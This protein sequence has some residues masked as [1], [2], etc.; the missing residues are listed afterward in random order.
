MNY[1]YTHGES[2]NPY[3]SLY[4]YKPAGS[5]YELTGRKDSVVIEPM[6]GQPDHMANVTLGIKIRNFQSYFSY[7]YASDK[8][9]GTHPNDL[10]LYVIRE[11]YSRLDFNA[12]YSFT[13]KNS[14]KLELILQV[15]NLNNSE[16]RIRYRE[17]FRPI[18]VEQY[19]VTSNLGVR[20]TF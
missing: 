1:T 6:T 8:I 3:T 9:E 2:P 19:G 5:R 12:S 17:E 13:F 4:K 18:S 7:Q 10:R 15:A 14:G 11:K 20:Y 16:D